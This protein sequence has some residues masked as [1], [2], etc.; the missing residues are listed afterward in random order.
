MGCSNS[1]LCASIPETKPQ[2]IETEPA[3][4]LP[5]GCTSI[6][7]ATEH[8]LDIT[9]GLKLWYRL[10]GN[11][12]GIP[13]LFVHGGPGNCVA[14]YENVNKKFFDAA[15]FLPASEAVKVKTLAT[16]HNSYWK[17]QFRERLDVLIAEAIGAQ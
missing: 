14:D 17:A 3:E 7:S 11:P 5:A 15:R 2:A 9:S 1:R 16:P 4:T 13:V 8:F 12:L 6:E 10:W